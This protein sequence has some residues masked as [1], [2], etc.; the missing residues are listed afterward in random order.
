MTAG[1]IERAR[2][3][4][5]HLIHVNEIDENYV[6]GI[7]RQM[8]RTHTSNLNAG[9]LNDVIVAMKKHFQ[10]EPQPTNQ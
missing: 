5:A 9:Q 1:P 4:L 7:A 6:D 10:E 3:E 2:R 8:F